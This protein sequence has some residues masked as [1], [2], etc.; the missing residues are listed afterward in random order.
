MKLI[1]EEQK[2]QLLA[3][4]AEA[5]RDPLNIDGADFKPVVKLFDPSGAATWLL[6]E[7]DP[8]NEHLAFGLADLGFG[9]P[10]LGYIDLAEI[11]SVRNRFGLAIERDIHFEAENTIAEYAED[12]RS[13]GYIKT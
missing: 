12:A 10:E 7:L 9:C 2:T 13:R 8:D 11:A 5:R 1:T 4:S 3:N 6:T